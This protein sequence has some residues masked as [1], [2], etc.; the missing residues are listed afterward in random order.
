[1]SIGIA[2]PHHS[3]TQPGAFLRSYFAPNHSSFSPQ[4]Q[5]GSAKSEGHGRH[6]PEICTIGDSCGRTVAETMVEG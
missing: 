4:T 3:L 5:V 1:M 2:P 6:G